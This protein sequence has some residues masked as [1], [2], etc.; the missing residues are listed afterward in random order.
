MVRNMSTSL[1]ARGVLAIVVGVI[2]ISWPGVTVLALAILF[3]VYAYMAAILEFERA[4]AGGGAG[5][6]IE[7]LLLGVVDVAAGV[8]SIVWPGITIYALVLLI[9]IWA[10][11]I[12]FLDIYLA[13][14]RGESGGTRTFFILYGL[15]GLALGVVLSSRPDVGALTLALLYGLFSLFFGVSQLTAGIEMRRA[16]KKLTA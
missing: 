3:A 10:F 15:L 8:I 11:V 16:V 2:A 4:F 1:I 7:H 6:V 5:P 12:G 9:A 13:F 14:R